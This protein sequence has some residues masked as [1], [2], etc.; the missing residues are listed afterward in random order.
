MREAK[1]ER[2]DAF[3]IPL[4]TLH[5]DWHGDW[6]LSISSPRNR[7]AIASNPRLAHRPGADIAHQMG[8]P[9]WRP[10]ALNAQD[11]HAF[12]VMREAPERFVYLVGLASLAPLIATLIDGENL[13]AI[14]ADFPLEDLKIALGCRK[15]IA[16]DAQSE[17]DPS[18]LKAIVETA[19]PR[20]IMTW[21]ARLPP[22]ARGRLRLMLP[23][24]LVA[25]IEPNHQPSL[26]HDPGK[27]IHH[28]ANEISPSGS[29]EHHHH[30]WL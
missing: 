17:I 26:N 14:V 21:G 6:G 16:A 22:E 19:G 27:V 20:N 15:F 25:S 10:G 24:S 2:R 4:K 23:K 18:R 1:L 12:L 13:R 9:E 28:V 11:H 5:R 29:L 30:G 7:A 8:I 3:E